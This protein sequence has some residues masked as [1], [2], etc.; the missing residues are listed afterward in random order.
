MG[1][2]VKEFVIA[3]M[4]TSTSQVDL[5]ALTKDMES[6]G[7]DVLQSP[8]LKQKVADICRL[9]GEVGVKE[10]RP[11]TKDILLQDSTTLKSS[12]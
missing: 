4:I 1:L 2:C 3:N 5:A 6:E 7:L 9:R 12:K 8:K 11:I 10:R